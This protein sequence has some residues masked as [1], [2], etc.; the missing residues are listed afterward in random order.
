[1]NAS[2]FAKVALGPEEAVR[3][4]LVDLPPIEAVVV[5]REM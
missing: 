3:H 5:A 2:G 4:H 1:M